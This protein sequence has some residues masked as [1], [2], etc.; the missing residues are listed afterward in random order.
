MDQ[1]QVVAHGQA[2]TDNKN[3]IKF[4]VIPSRQ[5]HICDV[6]LRDVISL[7]HLFEK[8]FIKDV[9]PGRIEI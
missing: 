7:I 4:G 8:K 2:M 9:S 1:T 5:Q 6:L 3:K